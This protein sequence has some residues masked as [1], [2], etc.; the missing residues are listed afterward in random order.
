LP[1]VP[2]ELLPSKEMRMMT[3]T[4]S[5]TNA[6]P[7][8]PAVCPV[9]RPCGRPLRGSILPPGRDAPRAGGRFVPDLGWLKRSRARSSAERLSVAANSSSPGRCAGLPAAGAPER[10]AGGLRL[11]VPCGLRLPLPLPDWREGPLFA[12]LVRF[13]S[14]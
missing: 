5:T 4:A 3:T 11:P 7:K 2:E 13:P 1:A 9:L 8:R 14:W 10:R 12:I 6:P